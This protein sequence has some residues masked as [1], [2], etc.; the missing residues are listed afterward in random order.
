M[1]PNARFM[2]RRFRWLLGAAIAVALTSAPQAAA[3]IVLKAKFRVVSASGRETAELPGFLPQLQEE[4]QIA[5]RCNSGV[6]H[7]LNLTHP[8]LAGIS[9]Q[10]KATIARSRRS[11]CAVLLTALVGGGCHD[12]GHE[13]TRE[14]ASELPLRACIEAWNRPPNFARGRPG[15]LVR[16]LRPRPAVP[17]FAHVSRDRRRCV[18]FLDTPSTVDDRRF[19]RTRG[20]FLTDCA[21]DCGQQ[22]PRGARTLQFRS[23]GSLP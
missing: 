9:T 12:S 20:A 10:G 14:R 6:S 3:N 8:A 1:P 11:V 18:V 2:I 5:P 21:G 22:V 23:D 15:D 16:R 19:V 4:P 17:L 7:R 13:Q